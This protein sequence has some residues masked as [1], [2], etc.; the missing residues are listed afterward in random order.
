MLSL[1]ILVVLRLFDDVLLLLLCAATSPS[2][3]ADDEAESETETQR[4]TIFNMYR[5]M[6]HSLT[7]KSDLKFL[8]NS[9]ARLLGNVHEAQNTYL[10]GSTKQISSYQE[11]LVLLWK[12]LDENHEFLNELLHNDKLMPMTVSLLFMMWSGRLDP[13]KVGIYLLSACLPLFLTETF[14]HLLVST[15]SGRFGAHLHIPDVVAVW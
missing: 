13:A 5:S 4:L 10:P 11:I 3:E 2:G 12:L 6:L 8:I 9:I 1:L 7:D 15:P 14:V